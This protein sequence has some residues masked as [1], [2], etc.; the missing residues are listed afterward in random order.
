MANTHTHTPRGHFYFHVYCTSGGA[1]VKNTPAS[2][3]EGRDV[4]SSPGVGRAPGEENGNPL[5]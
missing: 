2:A 1:V 4:G 3:G 5:Q